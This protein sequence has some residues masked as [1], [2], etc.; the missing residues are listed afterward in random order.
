MYLAVKYTTPQPPQLS[1]PLE[2]REPPHPPP[3]PRFLRYAFVA[4]Y[5]VDIDYGV[6][7]LGL[8]L[9]APISTATTTAAAAAVA[10]AAAAA[11]TTTPLLRNVKE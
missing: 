8:L 2:A 4:L 3:S 6:C 9:L 1:A 10:A 7:A 11:T 5:K